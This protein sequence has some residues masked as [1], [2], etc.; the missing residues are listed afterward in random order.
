MAEHMRT[1]FFT[2][3]LALL[4]ASCAEWQ[5]NPSVRPDA[6]SSSSVTMMTETGTDLGN[7]IMPETTDSLE[8]VTTGTGTSVS[9]FLTADGTIGFGDVS[10]K[11]LPLMLEFFDYDC[12]YCR[13]HALSA[14]AWIDP[15]YI[16]TGKLVVERIFLPQTAWGQRLASAAHCA[17][18]LNAF[19]EMDSLLLRSFPRNET[20]L[21]VLVNRAGIERKPFDDCMQNTEP[22]P[23]SQSFVDSEIIN[24]VPAFRIG[25]ESWLGV[26]E[27]SK[28][29]EHLSGILRK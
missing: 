13:E 21:L 8:V 18:V 27:E 26:M 23:N 25:N 9:G 11:D 2:V 15:E 16:A 19:D 10:E 7:E 12:P 6:E 14:R 17:A 5:T 4:L 24:R 20:A 22:F 3:F 28:L 29:R 1:T